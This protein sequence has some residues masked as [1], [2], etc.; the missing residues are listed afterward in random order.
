MSSLDKQ[1]IVIVLSVI[2]LVASIS[3]VILLVQFGKS[4]SHIES[5]S[6]PANGFLVIASGSGYNGSVSKD[7]STPWPIIKVQQGTTVNI[8]VCNTDVQVHG[9]QISFY[10]SEPTKSIAP[11]EALRISF[12]ADQTGTFRIYEGI[13]SSV[14]SFMQ[15]GELIVTS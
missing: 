7:P 10:H 11:G 15:N 8:V 4:P 5:C 6:K 13:S 12:I 3:S 9:F 2:L 14:S 1:R